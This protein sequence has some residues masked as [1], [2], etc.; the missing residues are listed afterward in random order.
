MD[1]TDLIRQLRDAADLVALV[2]EKT[3]LRKT[4]SGWMGACPIHG[5]GSRTPCFSVMPERG[6]WHCFQCGAGGDALDFLQLTQ[7]LTFDEALEDLSARTGIAL[8]TRDRGREGAAN[9]LEQILAQAQ[10]FYV[11]QLAKHKAA[12]DYLLGERRGLTPELIEAEGLGYAPD[13]WTTTVDHLAAAGVAR[14]QME[15]AGVTART[16][17]GKLI[18][19]LRDRITIPIRDA[20]GHIIAFAGRSLPGAPDTSPKYL[21]TRET[22][23]FKKSGALFHLNRAKPFLREEG[24]VVV[25]GYFDAV[26]MCSAGIQTAVAPMGTALTEDH[27]KLLGRWTHQ[28]TLAF[29]GDDAGRKATGRALELA[30]P[31]GFEVRLLRMPDG[32]DPDVWA[33][34]LNGDTRPLVKAAP[35]WATFAL[36][37]AKSGRDM[38]RVEDR[39]AAAQEVARWIGHLPKE[40]REEI[41]IVA[42]H[43]LNVPVETVKTSTPTKKEEV[44]VESRPQV[45]VEESIRCLLGMAARGGPFL[46]WVKAVPRGWWSY[47]PGALVL[48]NLLDLEGEWQDLPADQ[49]AAVRAAMATDAVQCQS[50]PKR[51]LVH[52]EREYL[53]REMQELTRAIAQAEDESLSSQ[54][55]RRLMELRAR[56]ARLTRGA[57]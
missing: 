33:R 17:Q 35:D 44:K 19:M 15:A 41:R 51:I 9:A 20:K 13:G 18:D 57:K 30:L 55:Q 22:P 52:L 1:R 28:L 54:L 53:Q 29:D 5:G 8:P 27:L 12:L 56:S 36:A 49:Q 7:A 42:A 48:E 23:I 46:D 24:A 50:D 10:E 32:Q 11:A 38:H 3:K 40:R 34:G 26:S 47:R 2:G 4:G 37:K 16:Q 25:E 45:Q 43:E 39:L 31:L 14:A 6:Q 21:N